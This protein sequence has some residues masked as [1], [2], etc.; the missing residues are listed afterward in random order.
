MSALKLIL[1]APLDPYITKA[2]AQSKLDEFNPEFTLNDLRANIAQN[3]KIQFN[4]KKQILTSN[5]LMISK[6]SNMN[7]IRKYLDEVKSNL[8]SEYDK[9]LENAS[10]EIKE[11]VKK[12]EIA[13]LE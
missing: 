5:L 3:H 4:N 11:N 8:Q 13:Y 1:E 2:E 7:L 9:A 12:I 10:E 6:N